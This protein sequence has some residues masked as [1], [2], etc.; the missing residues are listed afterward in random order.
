LTPCGIG[1][2]LTVALSVI[3]QSI[4][5]VVMSYMWLQNKL[6]ILNALVMQFM[7]EAIWIPL[8]FMMEVMS[9]LVQKF[10]FI[11]LQFIHQMRFVD[12]VGQKSLK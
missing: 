3:N 12:V 9:E 1:K 6:P 8:Q 10:L 2:A 7:N 11:K 5:D 4:Y